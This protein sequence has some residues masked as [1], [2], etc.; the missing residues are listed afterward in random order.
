[1]PCHNVCERISSKIIVGQPHYSLGKKYCKRCERYMFHE[2]RFFACC[3]MQLR[4]TPVRT[5]YKVMMK[6]TVKQAM[7]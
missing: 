4:T 5:H 6:R 1:M 7:P 3:G 2:G